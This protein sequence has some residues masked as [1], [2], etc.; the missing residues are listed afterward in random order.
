MRSREMRIR[1]TQSSL[2]GMALLLVMHA[3]MFASPARAQESGRVDPDTEQPSSHP[4]QQTTG[5][6]N[7]RLVELNHTLS[8]QEVPPSAADYRI[9]PDDQLEINVL[10][11]VELNREPRVSATGEI[12][13]A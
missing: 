11:A 10:E 8:Q 1:N 6:Y 9:G 13:L 7:R 2:Y 5:G 3:V 12:S 4:Y